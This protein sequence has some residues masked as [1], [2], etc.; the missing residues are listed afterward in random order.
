MQE[1]NIDFVRKYKFADLG[2]FQD[3]YRTFRLCFAQ[4]K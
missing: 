1:E 2:A 4:K 3:K